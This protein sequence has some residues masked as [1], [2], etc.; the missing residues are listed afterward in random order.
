MQYNIVLEIVKAY[1][2]Y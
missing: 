1:D 2:S